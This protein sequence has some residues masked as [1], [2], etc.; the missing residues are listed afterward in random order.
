MSI[1]TKFTVLLVHY[2]YPMCEC[3]RVRASTNTHTHAR[4]QATNAELQI[5]VMYLCEI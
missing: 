4:A 2:V 1:Q 3:V 5:P